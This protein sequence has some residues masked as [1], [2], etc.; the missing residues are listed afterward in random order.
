M[1]SF[2]TFGSKI[3]MICTAVP[4][5]FRDHQSN[6]AIFGEDIVRKFVK[7]TGINSRYI[8]AEGQTASDLGYSAAKSLIENGKINRS[9]IGILIYTTLSP[10]Y[11]R[12]STSCVLQMR[13]GLSVDCAVLDIGHG[14]AGFIYGHQAILSLMSSS[15]CKYGLLIC[16]DTLSRIQD[17]SDH[18][19]MMF[20]DASAAVLYERDADASPI[21]TMLKSDGSRYKTIFAPGGG[22]K[23]IHD[24]PGFYMD[25]M[26]VYKFSTTDVPDSITEYLKYTETTINDYDFVVLH[27][28]NKSII[29]VISKV[30]E[31]PENRTLISLD[32]YGNTSSASIPLTLSDAFGGE[33]TGM[34]RILACGFGVGLAWGVTSFVIDAS[35]IMPVIRTSE[36]FKD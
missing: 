36:S 22:F 23:Y 18:S 30:V 27:Q 24:N 35:D 26:E 25:G 20:G 34:M 12:P 32:R 11:R 9:E 29:R 16:G 33:K 8:A 3:K 2:S 19:S 28:A 13:L 14:C 17:E 4:E 7:S 10:D 21:H 5:D 31:I 1:P 6:C 15:E